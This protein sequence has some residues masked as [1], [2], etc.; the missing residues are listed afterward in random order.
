MLLLGYAVNSS[1]PGQNGCNFPD[2]IFKFISLNEKFSIL[3]QISLEFVPK[4]P[5]DNKW[6]L[7]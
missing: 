5:I 7:V 1:P 2:N 3:I 6:A 4:G